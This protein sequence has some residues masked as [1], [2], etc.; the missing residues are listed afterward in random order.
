VLTAIALAACSN[1]PDPYKTE[2]RS[3]SCAMGLLRP[4]LPPLAV[5]PPAGLA[6]KPQ[7]FCIVAMT[8]L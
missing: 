4:G 6:A 5:A 3:E 1:V 7:L 2:C 8:G